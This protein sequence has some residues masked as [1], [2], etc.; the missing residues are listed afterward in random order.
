M[1]TYTV[2]HSPR[3]PPVLV[4]LCKH[5]CFLSVRPPST[6]GTHRIQ[7]PYSCHAIGEK[8]EDLPK[9][10]SEC[11]AEYGADLFNC[12]LLL[13]TFLFFG[14]PPKL[15]LWFMNLNKPFNEACLGFGLV[16]KFE[17]RQGFVLVCAA[18]WKFHMPVFHPT[19]S[20]IIPRHSRPEKCR[21][22]WTAQF[23]SRR[24]WEWRVWKMGFQEFMNV[25]TSFGNPHS[26][27][28]LFLFPPIQSL[29]FYCSGPVYLRIW[30]YVFVNRVFMCSLN[31]S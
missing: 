1:G 26:L 10:C 16:K 4:G 25:T 20:A 18:L 15:I 12:C 29:C 22:Y 17:T 11:M 14:T 31:Y 24:C 9:T 3:P 30:H 5:K 23:I 8:G 6:L 2:D 7:Q 21:F 27:Q 28:N 13:Q 19:C